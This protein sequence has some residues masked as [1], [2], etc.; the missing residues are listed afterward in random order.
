MFGTGGRFG[1]LN[2]SFSQELVSHAV[3]SGINYF[4]TGYFYCQGE[5]QQRLFKCLKPY[6][7][8]NP[9]EIHISTKVPPSPV[10]GKITSWIY[11]TLEQLKYKDYIDTLFLWGPSIDHIDDQAIFDELIY[12]Q[13]QGLVKQIGV[14]SH[15]LPVMKRCV[16]LYESFSYQ[17]LMLDFN[18]L[19]QN[20]SQLFS[21]CANQH[22]KIWGEQLYQGS[23]SR[24]VK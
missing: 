12:L 15:E 14:N 11:K 22:L 24:S 1:R 8:S 23:H 19:Q 7:I 2:Q 20:R 18:L 16:D 10:Q 21:R 17:A 9:K 4:D 6:L 3:H 5:S 13:K